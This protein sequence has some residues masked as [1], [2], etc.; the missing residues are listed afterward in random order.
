MAD[1]ASSARALNS[2]LQ[3]LSNFLLCYN[4]PIKFNALARYFSKGDWDKYKGNIHDDER[5]SVHEEDGQTMI[6]RGNVSADEAGLRDSALAWRNDVVEYFRKNGLQSSIKLS[7]ISRLVPRPV[8]LTIPSLLILESDQLKKFDLLA[9]NK[10]SSD[11][12][13]KYV[14]S[15]EE[16]K[17]YKH[18]DANK[19]EEKKEEW[20]K[21]IISYLLKET[22]SVR[23]HTLGTAVKKPNLLS[24][25]TK[26]LD[27]I[28]GDDRFQISEE[29]GVES[30][31]KKSDN[32]S[33]SV[34]LTKGFLVEHWRSQL[35]CYMSSRQLTTM[36]LSD[37]GNVVPRPGMLPKQTNLMDVIT[38][39]PLC[40]LM[41]SCKNDCRRVKLLSREERLAK[42]KLSNSKSGGVVVISSNSGDGGPNSPSNDGWTVVG[43][44]KKSSAAKSQ[45]GG[46]GGNKVVESRVEARNGGHAVVQKGGVVTTTTKGVMVARPALRRQGQASNQGNDKGKN[47]VKGQGRGQGQGSG[48]LQQ[49]SPNGKTHDGKGKSVKSNEN[50]AKLEENGDGNNVERQQLSRQQLEKQGLK[51]QLPVGEHQ[52]LEHQ[53]RSGQERHSGDHI[54]EESLVV[55]LAQGNIFDFQSTAPG[56][57]SHASNEGSYYQNGLQNGS[58]DSNN[59][60]TIGLNFGLDHHDAMLGGQDMNGLSLG[61]NGG[62]EAG[63]MSQPSGL[64]ST[65][66]PGFLSQPHA[67]MGRSPPGMMLQQPGMQYVTEGIRDDTRS[68]DRYWI[69]S[70]LPEVFEGFPPATVSHFVNTLTD[71]GMV[72]VEDLQ[73]AQSQGQLTLEYFEKIGIVCKLGHY[74]RLI[75]ALKKLG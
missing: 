32:K 9:L 67:M 24:Y 17:A 50:E 64:I 11:V 25:K 68:P 33:I 34:S 45:N 10:K 60:V 37:I 73:M 6:C 61:S 53:Q 59:G 38:S 75:S 8:A 21:K 72:S 22:G 44:S 58:L 12:V 57:F 48:P 69:H 41:Y 15:Q 46:K 47:Q 52:L 2:F 36:L 49:K 18:I 29:G 14:Y 66:P 51:S 4:I 42:L 13:I 31:K 43:E 40:R 62:L 5:F 19:L 23:I 65:G 35:V 74:N 1:T 63:G 56:L 30:G 26:C 16:W 27:V 3:R 7:D 39:D 28:R 71:E 54:E 55:P 70:W 20:R